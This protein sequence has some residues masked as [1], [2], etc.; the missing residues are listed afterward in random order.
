VGEEFTFGSLFAGIGGFDLGLERAGMTCKWQVE[1]DPYATR[2]LA[3]H[4]PDVRRWDDVRTFPPAEGDWGVDL[5][6][7]GF[8]CQDI[9]DAGNKEGLTGQRS[10][11]WSEYKRIIREIQPRFMLVENVSALL[12]RGM[13]TVL[14][15]LASLGM[16]AEWTSL[17]ACALGAPHT[18]QRVFIVAYPKKSRWRHERP[19]IQIFQPGQGR[20]KTRWAGERQIAIALSKYGIHPHSPD[21]RVADEFPDWMDRIGACGNAVVP[22]VAEWIGRRIMECEHERTV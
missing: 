11:L 1:I 6:C 4:W 3:K 14:A 5:I 19:E 2:V 20:T 8:P 18:R 7:G 17:S 16:D 22:Q 21:M 12:K 13:G 10:G 9:S 15:D